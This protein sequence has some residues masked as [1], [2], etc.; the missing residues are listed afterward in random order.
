MEIFPSGSFLREKIGPAQMC[1]TF[2]M[3]W[4]LIGNSQS[5]IFKKSPKWRGKSNHPLAS[6]FLGLL[7]RAD[8]SCLRLIEIG[9]SSAFPYCS[10]SDANYRCGAA[11]SFGTSVATVTPQPQ[12][13]KMRFRTSDGLGWLKA[14]RIKFSMSEGSK[15][16]EER[17]REWNQ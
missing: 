3:H 15:R 14:Q 10:L 5:A 7:L 4:R 16:R 6:A 1:C 17:G 8:Y 11:G 12:S 13:D 9:H 2:P